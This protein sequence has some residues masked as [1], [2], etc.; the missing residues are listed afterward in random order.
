MINKQQISKTFIKEHLQKYNKYIIKEYWGE[1]ALSKIKSM[2]YFND[3]WF[4]KWTEHEIKNCLFLI[5][6]FKN[7]DK[8]FID[9]KFV[10]GNKDNNEITGYIYPKNMGI[11]I[12]FKYKLI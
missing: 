11:N 12:L 6:S 5:T 9:I 4:K 10:I 2:D 1:S 8:E 7:L 3:N